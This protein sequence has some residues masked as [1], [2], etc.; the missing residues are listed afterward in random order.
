MAKDTKETEADGIGG[1][2]GQA[3]YDAV[4]AD[5]CRWKDQ[6]RHNG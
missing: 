3:D 1:E 5:V 6:H 4:Y 2:G